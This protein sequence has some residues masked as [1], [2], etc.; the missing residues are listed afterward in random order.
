LGARDTNGQRRSVDVSAAAAE[1]LTPKDADL[2]AALGRGEAEALGTLY[3]RHGATVL[4]VLRRYARGLG[5][6]ELEDLRQE[7][8]LTA[9]DAAPRYRQSGSVRSWLCGIAIQLG[10]NRSRRARWRRGLVE[11]FGGRGTGVARTVADPV[12]GAAGARLDAEKALGG[13][14]SAQREVLLLHVV[15]ELSGAEIAVALGIAEKTVWTRLHRARK[16]MREALA[17]GE[18]D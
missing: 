2:V 11:R 10:R 5:D 9:L 7:A 3:E 1:G 16:A 12:E 4:G 15:E 6:A 18:G 8:F 14:P 17:E 13:L